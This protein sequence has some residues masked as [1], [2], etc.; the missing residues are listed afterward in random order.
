M[1]VQ[2]R[3]M[4]NLVG[5]PGY[6]PWN[7]GLSHTQIC[8]MLQCII[9]GNWRQL[10]LRHPTV[11]YEQMQVGTFHLNLL[12][13]TERNSSCCSM[14]QII[15]VPYSAARGHPNSTEAPLLCADQPTNHFS[16]SVVSGITVRVE[17]WKVR[18]EIE[19]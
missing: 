13:I 7:P 19:R 11:R 3:T 15:I 6:G 12:S 8:D 18:S 4:D 17:G 9:A 10:L 14:P 2:I 5:V 16:D 1:I